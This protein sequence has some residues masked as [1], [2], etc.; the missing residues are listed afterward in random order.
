MKALKEYVRESA[1]RELEEAIDHCEKIEAM[2][3]ENGDIET[4]EYGLLS[5]ELEAVI[6]MIEELESFLSEEV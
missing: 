2:I 5:Q 1:E 3:E 4:E 6:E